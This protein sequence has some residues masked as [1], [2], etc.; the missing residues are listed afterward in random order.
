MNV[1]AVDSAYGFSWKFHDKSIRMREPE[2]SIEN[3]L[4]IRTPPIVGR[5][6]K[7]NFRNNSI[8][9]V[10]CFDLNDEHIAHFSSAR[11]AS[12]SL[13]VNV[14]DILD[15]CYGLVE[16]IQGRKWYFSDALSG[17]KLSMT[18]DCVALNGEVLHQFSSCME[19]ADLLKIGHDEVLRCCSDFNRTCHGLR[20]RYASVKELSIVEATSL[21]RN[22]R[23]KIAE[24]EGILN[25]PIST[26]TSSLRA[27]SNRDE[28]ELEGWL[29][30]KLG[31]EFIGVKVRRFFSGVGHVDGVVE[32]Y[33]PGKLNDSIDL[34]RLRHADG[35]IEDIEFEE[36][37]KAILYHAQNITIAPDN[38][39]LLPLREAPKLQPKES[40]PDSEFL[41]QKKNGD[42]SGSKRPCIGVNYQAII[43]SKLSCFY[44][45]C[46][47]CSAGQFING[48]EQINHHRKE[49][50][51]REFL[52]CAL[53]RQLAPGC[54]VRLFEP[55][56]DEQRTFRVIPSWVC[57]LSHPFTDVGGSLMV[58]AY[59]GSE[60]KNSPVKYFQ[61]LIPEDELH[62]IWFRHGFNNLEALNEVQRISAANLEA[63]FREKEAELLFSFKRVCR[64]DVQLQFQSLFVTNR[65]RGY[66]DRS[67]MEVLDFYHRY[68]AKEAM[69]FPN[70]LTKIFRKADE[71]LDRRQKS[72]KR[73]DS[74]DDIATMRKVPK[75]SNFL[76]SPV[77]SGINM[78]D[79]LASVGDLNPFEDNTSP[80]LCI[81]ESSSEIA[82]RF[83]SP[84]HAAS[85]LNLPQ[86][87][88]INCMKLKQQNAFGCKWTR[89][90]DICNEYDIVE[91]SSIYAFLK[92]YADESVVEL[93]CLNAKAEIVRRFD[94]VRDAAASILSLTSSEC[95]LRLCMQE[96]YKCCCGLLPRAL[97]LDWRYCDSSSMEYSFHAISDDK[98]V[99]LIALPEIDSH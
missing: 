77:V 30:G 67:L 64:D 1:A 36:L 9:P 18:I 91:P 29:F 34:W 84:A 17:R 99:N 33:F 15:S 92:K 69:K 75:L 38:D 72:K 88:I 78:M 35:D 39:E 50:V 3:L 79:S 55:K 41:R 32:A 87:A 70:R 68:V 7:R 97:G 96:I 56:F 45:D 14:T 24:L 42:D 63:Q 8:I 82:C 6:A 5:T 25:V 90:A 53:V 21:S 76:C 86:V 85:L 4:E 54:V 27:C 59:D 98:F 28:M 60:T 2:L 93:E 10:E 31:N 40:I 44:P 73:R 11:E 74:A 57:V 20:F 23:N 43:P 19:A 13:R 95:S 66:H 26:E 37:E 94:S 46:T 48:S 58:C 71:V 83:S 49:K 62:E 65:L 81:P 16:S 61:S 47:D 22:T 80:V 12:K 52:H 89:A 51:Y